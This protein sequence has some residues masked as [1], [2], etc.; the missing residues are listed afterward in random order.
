MKIENDLNLEPISFKSV[1]DGIQ[2][3]YSELPF[4]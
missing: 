4:G 1:I 2:Y 3:W